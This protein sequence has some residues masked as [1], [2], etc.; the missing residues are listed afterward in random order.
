MFCIY[1]RDGVD[2]SIYY[3]D[4]Q[5]QL[6]DELAKGSRINATGADF[7]KINFEQEL[8]KITKKKPAKKVVAKTTSAKKKASSKTE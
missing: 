1:K 3:V 8:A 2:E 6:D 4:T 5:K 7:S